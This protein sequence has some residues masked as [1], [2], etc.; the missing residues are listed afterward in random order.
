MS[1]DSH[2][3]I[4]LWRRR[5]KRIFIAFF[6]ARL[7]RVE[8][9]VKFY[10][11]LASPLPTSSIS[12]HDDGPTQRKRCSG[13]SADERKNEMEI[14][15]APKQNETESNE[16]T[17][18]LTLMG[19]RETCFDD[20]VALHSRENAWTLANYQENLA[21]QLRQAAGNLWRGKNLHETCNACRQMLEK[22]GKLVLSIRLFKIR[23]YCIILF[24]LFSPR[25][26]PCSFTNV[27]FLS[28]ERNL[29]TCE[30]ETATE[31]RFFFV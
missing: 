29:M 1:L 15:F 22:L 3:A 11:R 5:Q 4:T 12:Y 26:H 16:I 25:R 17:H 19:D 23:L 9:I 7:R 24:C 30:S 20:L 18:S 8:L 28:F 10:K 31:K 2:V 21:T 27:F 6:K 14:E 13:M